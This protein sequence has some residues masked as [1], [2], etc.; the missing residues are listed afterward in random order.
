[1]ETFLLIRG[2]HRADT[3]V[4]LCLWRLPSAQG[5]TSRDL[6][7]RSTPTMGKALLHTSLGTDGQSK[8]EDESSLTGPFPSCI[9]ISS[10]LLQLLLTRG[11]N[12]SHHKPRRCCKCSHSS[13][14]VLRIRYA[15]AQEEGMAVYTEESCRHM[16]IAT[17][18]TRRKAR[19]QAVL[20]AMDVVL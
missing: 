12:C 7:C 10:L 8:W 14:R 19:L 11:M 15:T 18:A 4:L 16:I 6:V 13:G 20:E 2:W 17:T 1:M 9:P 5:G 3:W